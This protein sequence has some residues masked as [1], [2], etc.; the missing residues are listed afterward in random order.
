M[1]SKT[2]TILLIL[3]S[4]LLGGV[5]GAY[6][7]KT[8]FPSQN[9]GP[10]G[11][12]AEYQKMFAERLRLDAAQTGKVDSLFDAHR[13][14]FGE[15]KKTYSEIVR[16]KRDTLRME[17][18]KLL[19]PEQNALYDSFIKEQEEREKRRENHR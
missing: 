2:K 11:S 19:S 13:S 18:R 5:G 7:V 15:V 1:Q 16:Q 10:R 8:F 4:F 9:G 6:A 3:V 12:R 17:I 14:R